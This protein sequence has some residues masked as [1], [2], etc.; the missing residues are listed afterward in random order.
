MT[1]TDFD[2]LVAD[3]KEN[4]LR[5]PIIT[6]RET[7]L[8]GRNRLRACEAADVEP[9]FK[10][11]TGDDPVA[12]VISCNLHRRHL[13]AVQR[14]AIA[15]KLENLKRGGDRKSD[16]NIPGRFDQVSRQQA[17]DLLQVGV[18]SIDR[19]SL[20]YDH[21]TPEQVKAME[22]GTLPLRPTAEK[23]RR[24]TREEPHRG[25]RRDR[26]ATYKPET[27]RQRQRAQGQKDRMVTSLST[28]KGHCRGLS[29]F[30]VGM[31]VAACS[32]EDL[33]TWANLAR[34]NARILTAFALH[35]EKE[36]SS[37]KTKA[38]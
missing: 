10:E 34:E 9:R 16:Q 33:K 30:D 15:A 18:A 19:A 35:L 26:H 17:A 37:G 11:W 5:D 25:P 3:V 21:G 20:V 32:T 6:Y 8:D 13:N 24:A 4:G 22:R 36:F 12:F 14:A 38:A 27:E 2:E 23:L 31:A 7:I 29:T 1:G 28:I